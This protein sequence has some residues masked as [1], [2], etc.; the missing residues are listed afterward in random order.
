MR[1]LANLIVLN[2]RRRPV[3]LEMVLASILLDASAS[4][5]WSV[6]R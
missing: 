2:P 3:T 5:L 6:L 1:F 4:L